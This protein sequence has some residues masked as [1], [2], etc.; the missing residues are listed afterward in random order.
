M[1]SN[2]GCC[3]RVASAWTSIGVRRRDAAGIGRP[4]RG[5]ASRRRSVRWS[6]RCAT[7]VRCGDALLGP[8]FELPPEAG[9]ADSRV[10]WK[11]DFA[12]IWPASDGGFD[13]VIGN[14]PY[15]N[16]RR[17]TALRSAAVK[18]YLRTHYQCA[19]GAYDLYV[20]FLELAF[21]VLRPGGLCGLIV[22]NK[23]AGLTYAGPCRAMLSEQTTIQ[24]I[25]DLSPMAGV[26]GCRRVP[27]YHHLAKAAAR[28]RAPDRGGPGRV[29][30]GIGGGSRRLYRA[31]I[32]V[33]AAAGWHLHGT[34]DVESR[35]TTRPLRTLARTAQRYD[36]LP[37]RRDGRR[38]DRRAVRH[39]TTRSGE[40]FRFVVSGN[41]D[42]YS[43]C[44]G[45]ARFMKRTLD[46]ARPAERVAGADGRQA[47]A[48]SRSRKLSLPG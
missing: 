4:W 17:L 25:V 13:A 9:G 36:R 26:P 37:S 43:I 33:V 32:V 5:P 44:W 8:D 2:A 6:G 14:P 3:C 23:L 12:C 27:V 31:A 22:P 40:H 46:P 11:R 42:R 47:A 30:S 35:V 20:L 10:D 16:I 29:G 39:A 38:V 18:Q 34:L 19:R 15:V 28:V 48:V 24:R 7:N 45:R 21:R 1:A 41:I